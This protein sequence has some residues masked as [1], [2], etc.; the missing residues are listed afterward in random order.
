MCFLFKQHRFL[1]PETSDASDR[2][3]TINNTLQLDSV[4]LTRDADGLICP[5]TS[6]KPNFKPSRRHVDKNK[7]ETNM[8]EQIVLPACITDRSAMLR[9]QHK[10]HGWAAPLLSASG[11]STW[12]RWCIKGVIIQTVCGLWCKATAQVV[13]WKKSI[14]PALWKGSCLQQRD[15][16]GSHNIL[17]IPPRK[18]GGNSR[19]KPP[20]NIRLFS[21][22][23]A[24]A[25]NHKSDA[26]SKQIE[27]GL[28]HPTAGERE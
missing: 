5:N 19:H 9:L 1:K 13:F 22:I 6:T 8:T 2:I 18:L 3:V 4:S 20:W 27:P 16:P 12:A 23:Y 24:T 21:L 14:G 11:R 25:L 10:R 15:A 7:N 28:L 17:F 26:L